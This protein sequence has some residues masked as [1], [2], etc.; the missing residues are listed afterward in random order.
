MA[1]GNCTLDKVGRPIRRLGRF[2]GVNERF[3]RFRVDD[4]VAKFHTFY[5]EVLEQI[6]RTPTAGEGDHGL[7]QPQWTA[8][9]PKSRPTIMPDPT[10]TDRE[11]RCDNELGSFSFPLRSKSVGRSRPGSSKVTIGHRCTRLTRAWAI[12]SHGK[13][14]RGHSH[15]N[16]PNGF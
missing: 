6:T 16:S 15:R 1:R 9:A 5:G 11:M 10:A 13:W 2:S 4:N 3:R 8:L 14:Q 7:T 12:G